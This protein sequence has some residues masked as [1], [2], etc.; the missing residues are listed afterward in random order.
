MNKSY[1]DINQ[2]QRKLGSAFRKESP[3]TLNAFLSLHKAA[4]ASGTMETKYKE[5]I[6]VAIAISV[7]CDGCIGSHVEAAVKAGASREELIETINVAILM[8]GGPAVIYG[9]QALAAVD[10]FS[11]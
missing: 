3:D 5:L 11:R 1:T 9:T 7:R 2:Q 10:E 8:G 4:F 6:A